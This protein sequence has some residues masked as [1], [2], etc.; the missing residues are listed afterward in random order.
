MCLRSNSAETRKKDGGRR[1][2]KERVVEEE[3]SAFKGSIITVLDAANTTMAPRPAFRALHKNVI[4]CGI[5]EY[6]ALR[7]MSMDGLS[8]RTGTLQKQAAEQEVCKLSKV[9]KIHA[10]DILLGGWNAAALGA[11]AER[12]PVDNHLLH[13]GEA[14]GRGSRWH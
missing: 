11:D 8:E 1:G 14:R 10:V 2:K 4:I 5:S 13:G 7:K 9:S 3:I 6:V 12:A